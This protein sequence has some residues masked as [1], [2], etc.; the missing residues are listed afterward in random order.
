MSIP[1][2]ICPAAD[3]TAHDPLYTFFLRQN[4]KIVEAFA[5]TLATE[6]DD[7]ACALSETAMSQ[8]FA[9]ENR[10]CLAFMPCLLELEQGKYIEAGSSVAEQSGLENHLIASVLA[11]SLVYFDW[12]CV[13]DL[14][15]VVVDIPAAGDSAGIFLNKANGLDTV[16]SAVTAIFVMS[17]EQWSS[18]GYFTLLAGFAVITGNYAEDN[19]FYSVSVDGAPEGGEHLWRDVIDPE[20]FDDAAV[21]CLRL[22]TVSGKF[23]YRINGWEV[24]S[25]TFVGYAHPDPTMAVHLPAGTTSAV[26]FRFGDFYLFNTYLDDATAQAIEAALIVKY[27]L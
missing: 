26:T 16:Q 8:V 23:S 18:S 25:A 2:N 19:G 12:T 24:F 17:R 13:N 7:Q 10:C 14:A 1:A 21:H 4:G 3:T 22:D 15:G 5:L 27:A 20:S 6:N 11:P 9:A